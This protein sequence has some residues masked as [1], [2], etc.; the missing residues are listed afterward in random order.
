MCEDRSRNLIEK[1][2]EKMVAATVDENDPRRCF[3]KCLCSRKA[4]ETASNDDNPRK[5]V[6]HNRTQ[7]LRAAAVL[8]Y[9]PSRKQ[10]V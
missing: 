1:P 4:G 9:W 3:A 7:P 2:L 6:G 5:T 10:T 8:I